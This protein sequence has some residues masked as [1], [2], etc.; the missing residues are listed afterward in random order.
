MRSAAVAVDAD[1][2]DAFDANVVGD[3]TV[4]DVGSDDASDR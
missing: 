2:D 3:A 4:V 1:R